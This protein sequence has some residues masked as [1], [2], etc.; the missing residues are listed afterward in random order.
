MCE[1]IEVNDVLKNLN[2]LRA[3]I[4]NFLHFYIQ[5]HFPFLKTYEARQ[6]E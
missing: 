1:V 5:Q 4:L 6:I 3:D 2:K